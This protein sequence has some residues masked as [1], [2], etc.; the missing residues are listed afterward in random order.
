M[1]CTDIRFLVVEDHPFQRDMLVRMLTSLGSAAVHEAADGAAAL[2]VLRDSARPVDIVISDLA[3]PGMDGLEFV[4]RLSEEGDPVSLILTS[5]LERSLLA[6]VA[7]MARAYE[8]NLLGVVGKPLS[9]VKLAPLIASH[10]AASLPAAPPVDGSGIA[11]EDIAPAWNRDEFEPWFEPMA[12][13]RTGA[14]VGMTAVARWRN[15]VLG[16]LLPATFRPSLAA[17]GLTDNLTWLMLRKS[18]AQCRRWREAGHE[19]VV[20]VNLDLDSLTAADLAARVKETVESQQVDPRSVVLAIDESALRLDIPRTLENLARLRLM[21]FGLLL[22]DFGSSW[23]MGEHLA[24]VAFT[25][26]KIK[27]AFVHGKFGESDLAGIAVGLEL[28]GQLGIPAIAAGVVSE[29]KWTL[30]RD[31]DCHYAQ[32][33]FMS[34]AMNAE[35]VVPWLQTWTRP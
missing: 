32:G 22:D 30:L 9:A 15:P 2:A 16:V 26:L 13:L 14:I 5:A 21:G 10:R 1:P 24:L 31:W 3:M 12:D 19:L 25:Q 23:M 11:G 28:A 8:V 20:T 35:A 33:A 18:A 6:S 17:R 27:G 34:S 4:R 29:A 7:N